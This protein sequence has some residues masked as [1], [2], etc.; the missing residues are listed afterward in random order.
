MPSQYQ[1]WLSFVFDRPV[2][3]DGWYSEPTYH[4]FAFV[5]AE[6]AAL[7]TT[8]MQK[9]GEDLR[10]YSD[11]QVYHGLEYIFTNKRSNF[12]FSLMSDHVPVALRLE[13]IESIKTLYRDCFTPRCALALSDDK[14][15]RDNPLNSVCYMLW[16][17]SPLAYW[18]GHQDKDIF[19]EAIARVMEFALG[20]TNPACVESGLHGLGHIH[21][22]CPSLVEKIVGDYLERGHIE[23]TDL[24]QYA[25]RAAKGMVQ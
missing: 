7:F 23:S 14:V 1:E 17:I 2:T 4:E 8:T 15:A 11:A 16:D 10:R 3:A 6:R 5:P 20:S 24:R 12:V 19:Y 18:E 13:A 9:C 22:Y 25:T 21:M